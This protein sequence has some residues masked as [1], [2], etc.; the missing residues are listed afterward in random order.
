MI[1][2]A[3][4]GL[5]ALASAGIVVVPGPT[6]TVIVANALRHGARA[7]LWNVVGTQLGL[8]TMLVSL[9]VG[10]GAIVDRLGGALEIVRLVGAAYLVWLGASLWRAN[11]GSL[12]ETGADAPGPDAPGPR[13]ANPHVDGTGRAGGIGKR[14]E[15][16]AREDLRAVRFVRQGFL[17]IWAN[18]KALVFF[19]AFIPQFVD[20]GAPAVPQLLVLGA[21]F[22]A[23]GAALDG[24]Y[25]LAAGRAGRWLDRDRARTVE[26]ASGT[27][28]IGGGL[29]LAAS[30]VRS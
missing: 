9:A 2:A 20:A 30:G 27:C 3:T 12:L 6:V 19:G 21:T 13:A 23:V 16:G 11:G 24:A 10:F 8:A 15:G 25:A 14:G 17:V 5:F 29:W 26:R 4:L 28:L 1:D 18:P 7:G 22:M